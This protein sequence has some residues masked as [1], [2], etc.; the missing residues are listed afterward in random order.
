MK[1]YQFFAEMQEARLSKSGSKRWRPFTRKMLEQGAS[2]NQ[3][4]S[5]LALILT[6]DGSSPWVVTPQGL[7]A[8]CVSSIFDVSNSPVTLCGVSAGYLHKRCVRISEALA[9]K[10]HP[11][12]FERIDEEE[13]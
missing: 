5:C 3:F 6:D 9:R 2:E 10:L 7:Q 13:E 8:D 11:A 12:L 1:G 4:C